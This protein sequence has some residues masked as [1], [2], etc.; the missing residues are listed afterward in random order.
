MPTR[1]RSFH[2]IAD[3]RFRTAIAQALVREARALED[4][5]TELDRHAPY[6]RTRVTGDARGQA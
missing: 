4:Y 6:A 5:R 2:W 3:A 1:T